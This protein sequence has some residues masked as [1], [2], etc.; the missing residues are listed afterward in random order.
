MAVL[1]NDRLVHM[2]VA[3]MS[4]SNCDS[5]VKLIVIVRMNFEIAFSDRLVG[6]T[7]SLTVRVSVMSYNGG[8]RI[9]GISLTQ[10]LTCVRS[11]AMDEK[12][13][14]RRPTEAEW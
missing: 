3:S 10:H 12:K 6:S 11:R 14:R 7:T 1:A 13:Y 2:C 5:D 4:F 9:C 8:Q